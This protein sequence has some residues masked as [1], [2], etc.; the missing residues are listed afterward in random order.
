MDQAER[1]EL[2]R[3]MAA[4]DRV[5]EPE[6]DQVVVERD[7]LATKETEEDR[8][9]WR[10]E[11]VAALEP[12]VHIQEAFNMIGFVRKILDPRVIIEARE[13]G[14]DEEELQRIQDRMQQWADAVEAEIE[15]ESFTQKQ[16][17][18]EQ[19]EEKLFP[20]THYGCGCRG[21][22]MKPA[23][24]DYQR[25]DGRTVPAEF[26]GLCRCELG[27]GKRDY[28]LTLRGRRRGG[29]KRKPKDTEDQIPF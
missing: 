2:L 9:N 11:R 27:E 15:G 19:L 29:G 18:L 3:E 16:I 22:G 10:E 17:R 6:E 12:A 1:E 26:M 14:C 25:R 4:K 24:G 8:L 5:A 21:T 28:L 23:R 7:E 13:V 20:E